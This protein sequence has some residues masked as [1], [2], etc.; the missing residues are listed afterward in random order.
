MARTRSIVELFGMKHECSGRW[1]SSR[2]WQTPSIIIRA[3]TLPGTDGS[4]TPRQLLQSW[5]SPMPFQR[6]TT[7]PLFQSVGMMPVFQTEHRT[8]C[9]N[10]NA[11]FSPALRN[12]SWM[13]HCHRPQEL[14]RVSSSSPQPMFPQT[15]VDHS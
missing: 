12:S 10:M 13:P 15:K 7:R 4:F 1:C 8:A 3:K 9:N 5:R 6:K 2:W 11:A 14:S